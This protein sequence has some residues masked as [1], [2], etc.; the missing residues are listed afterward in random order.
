MDEQKRPGGLTALA[1][2]NFILAAFSIMGVIGI[3]LSM[4][5]MGNMST[6]GMPETAKAR[7]AAFQNIDPSVFAIMIGMSIITVV[8]LV[9]SGIGFLQ[10]KKVLGRITGN[11]YGF[12]GVIGVVI[13][14]LIFPKE[15]GGGFGISTIIGLVYP[16]LTLIL[17]D[18]SFKN[19]LNN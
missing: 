16:T 9:L 10:Q 17:L 8:L 5:L 13:S 12:Y 18:T 4:S 6:D 19:D 11:I 7:I 14:M 1:V 15:I 2:I 3:S